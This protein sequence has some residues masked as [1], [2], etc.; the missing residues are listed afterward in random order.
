MEAQ[1][2]SASKPIYQFAEFTLDATERI[3]RRDGKIVSLTPKAFDLL[4]VL[5]ENAGTTVE[6]DELMKR[7]WPDSFVE[8]ANL[9]VNMTSLRRALCEG[10][11]D[12]RYIETVPRRGYRFVASVGELRDD[13]QAVSIGNEIRPADERLITK[14]RLRR[15]VMIGLATFIVAAAAGLFFYFNRAGALT[16][17]DTILLADFANTTGDAVL[18]GT[19]KTALALQLEQSPF[20]NLFSDERVREALRYMGRSPDE[21]VTKEIAREICER[22]GIKAVLA[23]TVSNLGSHYVIALIATNA[24]TGD[25]LAREQEEAES[26]EQV[27]SVLG[28]TARRLREKLGESMSTI[29]KFDAPMDVTTSSLEAFN[30]F[31]VGRDLHLKGKEREAIPLLRRAVDIDPQFALG[32]GILA[33]T[34]RNAGETKLAREYGTKA[35]ELRERASE[36]EKLW[37][38]AQYYL[39]VSR[40]LENAIEAAGLLKQIY[41]RYPPAHSVLAFS[42]VSLGQ[43][44]KAVEEFQEAVRLDPNW[45]VPYGEFARQLI[46]LGRFAEAKEVLDQASTQKLDSIFFHYNLY[47]IA[48]IYGDAAGMKQQIDWASDRPNGSQ[49]F[50][51]WQAETA[52]FSGQMRQVQEFSRRE[53]ELV[54]SGDLETAAN[55]AT[56]DA[57]RNAFLGNCRQTRENAAQALTLARSSTSKVNVA[58]ALA[59]CGEIGQA[60]S[61]ANDLANENPK[62]TAINAIWL[63]TIRAAIEIRK[64]NAAGAIQLLQLVGRYEAATFFWPNYIRAQ[65]YL[66]QKAGPEARAEFQK[67]LEHR[68]WDPTSYL[69][70]LAHLGLA[71]AAAL[72]GDTDKSRK[73]YEDF[74]ALWKNADSDIPV[75]Q[76]AKLEYQRLK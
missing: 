58:I 15:I 59:M 8:E 11:N 76:Q 21:R 12:H 51:W 34:C 35:F 39:N 29:Q 24:R 30:A 17:K 73:A 23:G 61:L 47:V 2:V 31:S 63:P 38:M 66:R 54:P 9:S 68:G 25:V 57:A 75:L 55:L 45:A 20:L 26:I 4:L 14:P 1:S 69:Y 16:D 72:T 28:K 50:A 53:I 6:K 71:R 22:Q 13:A 49:A 27:L 60:R 40:E 19:L 10:S 7:I 48:F 52:A 64:G 65:A 5:V 67:I 70:P 3:L 56:Q 43:T 74:F 41:P 42:Y 33:V 37:I 32:Y 44:E 46:R 36:R 18:D 62:D